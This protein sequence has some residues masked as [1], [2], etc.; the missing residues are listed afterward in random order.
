[1]LGRM[2]EGRGPVSCDIQR[3]HQSLR[4]LSRVRV[5]GDQAAATA[6]S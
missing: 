2:L 4:M 1:M 3:A 6:R 5:G